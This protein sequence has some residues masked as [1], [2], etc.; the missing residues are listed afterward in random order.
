MIIKTQNAN[1]TQLTITHSQWMVNN[2][3]I[4]DE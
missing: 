3:G 1:L 4:N 2:S